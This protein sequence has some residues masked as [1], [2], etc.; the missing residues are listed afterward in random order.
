MSARDRATTRGFRFV[1]V[2]LVAVAFGWGG[3]GSALAD[4]GRY[5]VLGLKPVRALFVETC[6]PATG[7][8]DGRG[9][10]FT[11]TSGASIGVAGCLSAGVITEHAFDRIESADITGDGVL[12]VIGL[13][14]GAPVAHLFRGR[15]GFLPVHLQ[16]FDL[17]GVARDVEVADLDGNGHLDLAFALGDA[18]SVYRN[19]G[20]GSM[21]KTGEWPMPEAATSI[22]SCDVNLDGRRELI[23]GLPGSGRVLLLD[24]ASPTGASAR[25][26]IAR[27]AGVSDV[28]SADIDGDGV[29]D[30]VIASPVTGSIAMRGNGTGGFRPPIQIGRPAD[31]ILL[32]DFDRDG[33]VD[34]LLVESAEDRFHFVRRVGTSWV[35]DQPF[36]PGFGFEGACATDIDADGYLDLVMY[37]PSRTE[38]QVAT[39]LGGG[40]FSGD[41]NLPMTIAGDTPWDATYGDFNADGNLDIAAVGD[42]GSLVVYQGDGQGGFAPAYLASVRRHCR[43]I[44]T[45]DF[46]GDGILDLAVSRGDATGRGVIPLLGVGDGTFTALPLVATDAVGALVA[47]SFTNRFDDRIDLVMSASGVGGALLLAGDGMGSFTFGL[48]FGPFDDPGTI[49]TADVDQDGYLDVLIGTRDGAA[50]R[51]GDGFGAFP[52]SQVFPGGPF[53]CDGVLRDVDSDGLVDVLYDTGSS[54][55]DLVFRKNLGNRTYAAPV[56]HSP[57]TSRFVVG[58]FDGDRILD[59][60]SR[61]LEDTLHVDRGDGQGGFVAAGQVTVQYESNDGFVAAVDLD[62]DGLTD[63][64]S[65]TLAGLFVHANRSRNRSCRVGTVDSTGVAIVRVDGRTGSGATRFVSVPAGVPAMLAVDAPPSNPAGP[66]PFVLYGYP[67]PPTDTSVT[68]QP[69]NLGFACQPTPVSGAAP[70]LITE[71]WNNTGR[72]FLGMSTQSSQP[73]PWQGMLPTLASGQTLW[74]QGLIADANAPNGKAAVTNGVLVVGD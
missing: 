31:R 14:A 19:E 72:R 62:A 22:T 20:F 49:E 39:G 12:D 34:I 45:A 33:L 53:G 5:R 48:W 1:A 7:C 17:S 28:A 23:V 67:L 44:A 26:D 55:N 61:G 4:S 74:L 64:V 32:E 66:A 29:L 21:V 25:R 6:A 60:A 3:A 59:V 54:S 16:S 40:R 52:N 46:D 41:F 36:V 9:M 58:D 38:L 27:L 65:G 11:G 2:F 13:A 24:V 37:H 47:G 30:L 50:L 73:A 57:T 10:V 8:A 63:F 70:G 71:I 69:R 15:T 51:Y 42:R 35:A 18:V 43:G 56:T 68:L